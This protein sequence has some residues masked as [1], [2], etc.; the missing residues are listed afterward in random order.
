VIIGLDHVEDP[1]DA[2]IMDSSG[3]ACGPAEFSNTL[4]VPW[5]E[6]QAH[7]TLQ[8]RILSQPQ[9][10]P[11][12]FCDQVLKDVST[13]L[14]LRDAQFHTRSHGPR[15]RDRNGFGVVDSHIGGRVVAANGYLIAGVL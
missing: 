5:D 10:G 14:K 4:V 1:Y 12:V 9:C 15:L 2:T 11:A 13:H 3:Q 6:A 7:G 8:S